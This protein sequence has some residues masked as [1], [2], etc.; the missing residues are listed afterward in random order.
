MTVAIAFSLFAAPQDSAGIAGLGWLA[1]CWEMRS[2]P[3][4]TE[5]QWMTPRGGTMLGMSRT[6][7]NDSLV[8]FEQIR[9]EKRD[10]DL[11]YVASPARQATAE[12][13]ATSLASGTVTFENPLHDFP[14]KIFYT[15]HGTDSMAAAIEGPRGGTTRRITYPYRRVA[16]PA[17]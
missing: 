11:Y 7:R 8:E 10:R 12:F 5:E 2:G 3:R 13:K 17:A 6:T 15:R 9:I 14:K 16:C 4:V 1:G